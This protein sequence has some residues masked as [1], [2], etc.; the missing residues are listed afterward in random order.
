MKGEAKYGTIDKPVSNLSPQH[1]SLGKT[2]GPA[3]C[4]HQGN[5]LAG[6]LTCL[7]KD[8]STGWGFQVGPK[9]QRDSECAVGNRA[10]RGIGVIRAGSQRSRSTDR[11]DWNQKKRWRK[12]EEA[13]LLSKASMRSQVGP[14]EEA[15]GVSL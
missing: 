5:P 14:E 7:T 8:W 12:A 3:A 11:G 1:T 4:L 13:G 9:G 2:T 6:P 10:R 15:G